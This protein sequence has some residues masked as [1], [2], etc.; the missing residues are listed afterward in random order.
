V[1]NTWSTY[2]DGVQV[3][4]GTCDFNL[5]KDTSALYIGAAGSGSSNVDAL[6]DEVAIYDEPLIATRV[7]AHHN[8]G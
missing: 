8:A 7:A 5:S 2:K 6:I 3:Y 4:S 1:T